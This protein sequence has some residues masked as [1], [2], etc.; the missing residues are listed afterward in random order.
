MCLFYSTG[1][2]FDEGGLEPEHEIDPSCLSLTLGEQDLR[3]WGVVLE[4][5]LM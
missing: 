3:Q 2:P 5:N 4:K 1:E